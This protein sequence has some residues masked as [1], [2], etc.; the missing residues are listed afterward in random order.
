MCIFTKNIHI[1]IPILAILFFS[2]ILMARHSFSP[3]C[4]CTEP[5]VAKPLVHIQSLPGLLTLLKVEKEPVAEPKD[6][7]GQL[8]LTGS[9]VMLPENIFRNLSIY[10]EKPST[11]DCKRAERKPH[12]DE[13][14][15]PLSFV[16]IDGETEYNI[17]LSFKKRYIKQ[18][19]ILHFL[20]N[21]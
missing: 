8:H 7:M 4:F 12:V 9:T 2:Q 17:S 3:L 10:T 21:I 15:S 16:K 5:Q 18:K 6:N 1:N 14:F 19:S 13:T 11:E 20:L